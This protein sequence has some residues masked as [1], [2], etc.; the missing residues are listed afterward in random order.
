MIPARYESSRFPGK[1]MEDLQGKTVI[2][3]TCEAVHKA[4]IFDEVIVVTDSE[5]I[6]DEIKKNGWSAHIS[7][8]IHKCGT[9]RIA[10][11]AKDIDADIIVNVQGDEP[12]IDRESL[13][14]VVSVLKKDITEEIDLSSLMKKM[15]CTEDINNPNNVKVITDKDDFAIY[16]SR[17]PIPYAKGD[18]NANY[19]KHIGVYAFRK[20]ALLDFAKLPIRDNEASEEIEAI[21]YIEHKRKIKMIEVSNIGLGIDTPEQLQRAREFLKKK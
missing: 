20:K 3:R 8:N 14:K 7:N 17:H 15:S 18:Y 10:E 12:F 1:L 6:F 13:K 11:A 16:F 21:R 9:D 4:N 19:Y 5:I 2:T